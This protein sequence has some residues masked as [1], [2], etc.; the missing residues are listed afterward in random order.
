MTT[1]NHSAIAT[2]ESNAASTWNTRFADLDA[3]IGQLTATGVSGASAAAQVAALRAIINNLDVENSGA[4]VGAARNAG[5][6]AG[7]LDN[8]SDRVAI[9][10][11]NA[12]HPVAYGAVGNGSTDDRAT[13]NTLFNTTMSAGGYAVIDR[14]YSVQS[15][16]T[17]PSTAQ[18]RFSRGGRFVVPSGVTLTINGPVD[19]GPHQI[20]DT[21]AG[22]TVAFSGGNA[23]R[24]YPQWWG[25]GTADDTD[26]FQAALDS[27]MD[28]FVPKGDYFVSNLLMGSESPDSS[29][30]GQRLTGEGRGSVLKSITAD[31]SIISVVDDSYDNVIEHITLQGTSSAG[32]SGSGVA[33]I[34]AL[35]CHVLTIDNVFIPAGDYFVNTINLVNTGYVLIK[36]CYLY[37]GSNSAIR[38]VSGSWTRIRD[39]TIFSAQETETSLQGLIVVDSTP[40]VWITDN[41]ISRGIS[42]GVLVLGESGSED[43]LVV[44]DNNDIDAIYDYG[45]SVTG[46]SQVMITNNWISAGK[47]NAYFDHTPDTVTTETG[48]IFLDTCADFCIQ[49]NDIYN[50]GIGTPQTY[51]SKGVHLVDCTQ[52]IIAHNRIQHSSSQVYSQDCTDLIFESNIVGQMG[53]S[54]ANVSEARY[55]FIESGTCVNIYYKNNIC[56]SVRF[57]DYAVVATAVNTT[58]LLTGWTNDG[59]ETLSTSTTSITSAI[60]SSGDG[61]ANSNTFSLRAGV[62]YKLSATLT[63]NSGTA[64]TMGVYDGVDPEWEMSPILLVAGA[65]D[66]YFR[67]S[68]TGSTPYVQLGNIGTTGNWSL[69]SVSLT[70]TDAVSTHIDAPPM[71]AWIWWNPASIANNASVT[72]DAIRVEYVHESPFVRGARFG[73]YVMVSA[74]YDLQGVVATAYVSSANYVK[75][76]LSNN[77]GG[78]VDLAGAVWRVRVI[79]ATQVVI[80]A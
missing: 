32:G 12:Y 22:G 15:N 52:G 59:Y 46:Y 35:R 37:A 26:S 63:L 9:A 49:N 51:T 60:N 41:Y 48:Q 74:P 31:T 3:A 7:T 18:L 67:A 47:T 44:I 54:E 39:C 65:N 30:W 19:A 14:P 29:N 72:S 1:Y 8:L 61:R 45:I 76:V 20:F 50:S 64:P 66:Y 38:S 79:K 55:G 56:K 6:T 42:P 68:L 13:L 77:T 5:L 69:A 25:T 23:A 57:Q 71:D 33:A 40:S 27:G 10:A 28:V 24:C 70:Q 73:D 53:G 62:M 17:V 36:N 21:S 80:P 4:E 58:N 11:A 34:Q 43:K 75:I 78:A 2:G 16:L